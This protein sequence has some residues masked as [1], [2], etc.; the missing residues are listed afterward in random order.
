MLN[1]ISS[2]EKSFF[3]VHIALAKTNEFM[4]C[5][6]DKH[7][8]DATFNTG[9]LVYVNT[10]HFCLVSGLSRRLEPKWVGPFPVE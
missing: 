1:F 6:A 5:S 2:Q 4:A 10:A 3:D 9:D 8:H 7:R